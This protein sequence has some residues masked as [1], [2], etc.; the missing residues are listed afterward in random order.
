MKQKETVLIVD[1]DRQNR[2]RLGEVLKG[3]YSLCFAENGQ[4][5]LRIVRDL[6]SGI[7]AILLDLIMPV[8][9]GVEVVRQLH[10]IGLTS[11]I[12]VLIFASPNQ[13]DYV[14]EAV[15]YGAFDVI[16]PPADVQWV[17]VKLMR[18]ID[19]FLYRGDF[20]SQLEKQTNLLHHRFRR[21]EGIYKAVR[22]I[23]FDLV[24]ALC[25][26]I[27]PNG[28]YSHRHISNICRI[29]SDLMGEI[30]KKYPEHGLTEEDV[31]MIS[32]ASV[33]HDIGKSPRLASE[34]DPSMSHTEKGW[35]VFSENFHFHNQKFQRYCRD[36]CRWHH[37]RWNGKGFPDGLYRNETPI[38]AQVVG[39][40]EAFD[41][42]T[43]GGGDEPCSGREAFE[44]LNDEFGAFNPSILECFREIHAELCD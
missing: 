41:S 37:E 3:D 24:G 7:S 15:L 39:F 23:A 35:S 25:S 43:R 9:D 30:R 16:Y 5:A 18:A 27:D 4:Q 21:Q 31:Y 36:I 1:D 44:K 20:D 26:V 19:Y 11:R 2:E 17:K 29:T 12:P 28:N 33:V 10:M 34:G 38:W 14:A 13:K 32:C 6:G 40:A 8:L 42:L 22:D